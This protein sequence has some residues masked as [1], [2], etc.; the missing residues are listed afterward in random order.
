MIENTLINTLIKR[1]LTVAVAESC[2]GGL[3]SH[4][5]TNIAGSSKYFLLGIIAYANESK[6]KFV[7]VS[8]ETLN[9]H[10]AVSQET[11]LELAKNIKHL[12][13]ANIGI[14]V[15]GIAGPGGGSLSKPVGTVF[16]AISLG[17]HDFFK[18]FQFKG[19]RLSIKTKAKNAALNL[20]QE[21]LQ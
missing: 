8:P 21:C 15:T 7:G 1:K 3:I 6:T 4:T 13:G 2:T 19:S 17:H 16:I 5:L 20:L 14:G 11:A 18:K 10:G 9:N 12:A